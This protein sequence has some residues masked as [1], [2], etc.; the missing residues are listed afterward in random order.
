MRVE[1]IG[2]LPVDP[3]W[4]ERS[5]AGSAA[6]APALAGKSTKETHQPQILLQN[7]S[8]TADDIQRDIEKM[9]DQ[10]ESM[11]RSIRFSVDVQTKDLVV[12]V[13]DKETGD[14]VMQIPP[15]EVLKLRER[16]SEMSGLLMVKQV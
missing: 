16:L 11:N 15:E 12:K 2:M 5:K 13:V 10:L 3:A 7:D 4:I 14:V 1:S 8:H 6:T 9:N